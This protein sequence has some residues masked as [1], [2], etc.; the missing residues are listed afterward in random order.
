MGQKY[1][2]DTNAVIDYLDNKLPTPA[3][4][5]I[6]NIEIEISVIVRIELLAW[7]NA[8]PA[9]LHILNSFINDATVINFE[10]A[11]ILKTIDVRKNHKLKLADAIIAATCLVYGYT[12]L[13]R[14]ISDFDKVPGLKVINPHTL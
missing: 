12:L 2:M 13:S 10:E 5:F 9:Q 7:Q 14:N 6:D 4:T 8:T 3:A 11:I 1:L